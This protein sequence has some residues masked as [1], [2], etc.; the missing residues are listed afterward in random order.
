M[1]FGSCSS[2]ERI[3]DYC[4]G[5]SG[6]EEV[7]IPDSVRE[8]CDYCF[9]WCESLHRVNFGS[10]SSLE[11]IGFQVFWWSHSYLRDHVSVK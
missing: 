6:V 7:S 1:T 5:S 3:G 4:F 2:L 11:R 8:M 10:S 9:S